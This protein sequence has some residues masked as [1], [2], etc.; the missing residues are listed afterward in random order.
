[1]LKDTL[2]S[3]PKRKSGSPSAH[4]ITSPPHKRS[5]TAGIS[6]SSLPAAFENGVAH[7]FTDPPK[8]LNA[9]ARASMGIFDDLKRDIDR[10]AASG[11]RNLKVL[12]PGDIACT[13][14]ERTPS[15]L[16]SR[17][18]SVDFDADAYEEVPRLPGRIST[19][20]GDAPCGGGGS[21]ATSPTRDST[22]VESDLSIHIDGARAPRHQQVQRM[23]ILSGS[24]LGRPLFCLSDILSGDT[25]GVECSGE[26]TY[27]SAGLPRLMDY[28]A[29]DD[30]VVLHTPIGD[31]LSDPAVHRS[32]VSL[33]KWDPSIFMPNVNIMAP[34]LG[35][36]YPLEGYFAMIDYFS[37]LVEKWMVHLYKN[38]I[39]SR[40]VFPSRVTHGFMDFIQRYWRPEELT[41]ARNFS[42]T[43]PM[44]RTFNKTMSGPIPRSRI[45][46]SSAAT[47]WR[48]LMFVCPDLYT[49]HKT[50]E[51]I[52]VENRSP[53]QVLF[54]VSP[55]NPETGKVYLAAPT[56]Q[57]FHLRRRIVL[58]RLTLLQFLHQRDYLYCCLPLKDSNC[59]TLTRGIPLDAMEYVWN[60]FYMHLSRAALWSSEWNASLPVNELKPVG[61]TLFARYPVEYRGGSIHS[62][63]ESKSYPAA[64][65][66]D[67]SDMLLNVLQVKSLLISQS[68]D[69]EMNHESKRKPIDLFRA[70]PIAYIQRYFQRDDKLSKMIFAEDES[71][72]GILVADVA[73]STPTRAGR[74]PHSPRLLGSFVPKS[75]T[76]HLKPRRRGVSPSPSNANKRSLTPTRQRLF[77]EA[78]IRKERLVAENE[79]L[80]EWTTLYNQK[81]A[82]SIAR[83]LLPHV[84]AIWAKQ[85]K[86]DS[87]LKVPIS[88]LCVLID[89]IDPDIEETETPDVVKLIKQTALNFLLDSGMETKL[90]TVVQGSVDSFACL[91]EQHPLGTTIG[92]TNTLLRRRNSHIEAALV[93]EEERLS[94]KYYVSD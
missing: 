73:L 87:A 23:Q 83:Q 91:N 50:L 16:K 1:M 35:G 33:S 43:H 11:G 22:R 42:T 8:R 3:R 80:D 7:T 6:R 71:S 38:K 24:C 58:R 48:Q 77:E 30:D 36:A 75:P 29:S 66:C 63:L 72:C 25:A 20:F 57:S 76:G 53:P 90:L 59:T 47:L 37:S 46:R 67:P 19:L 26:V 13:A 44:L 14:A 31:Y 34:A 51:T 52:D 78:R 39:D 84:N 54:Q 55:I 61:K 60:P 68:S 28:T 89:R 93:V 2:T 56:K 79:I 49:F 15:H 41:S 45:T 5:N 18:K 12:M 21:S 88:E 92:N 65:P 86:S 40:I 62:T 85:K 69:K 74:Q 64:W 4:R 9:P 10:D 17:R 81:K 70:D 32:V 82:C 27:L 94:K